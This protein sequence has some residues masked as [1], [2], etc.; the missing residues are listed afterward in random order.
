M[1]SLPKKH[2]I[3]KKFFQVLSFVEP[4]LLIILLKISSEFPSEIVEISP[5]YCE[6]RISKDEVFIGL[7]H[8]V[9]RFYPLLPLRFIS[10]LHI[11]IV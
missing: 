6:K 2:K 7:F 3:F 11:L 10:M 8:G 9:C 1:G 5:K 4:S